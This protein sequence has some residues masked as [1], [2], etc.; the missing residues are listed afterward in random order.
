MKLNDIN[1]E[2]EDG[3]GAVQGAVSNNS[4][5]FL[6]LLAAIP[7]LLFTAKGRFEGAGG[8]GGVHV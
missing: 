2:N 6:A 8:V 7:T 5:I 3:S 4:T 1:D